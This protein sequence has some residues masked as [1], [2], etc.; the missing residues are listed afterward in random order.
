MPLAHRTVGKFPWNSCRLI[1]ESS[2]AEAVW[3]N[4][5]QVCVKQTLL[6]LAK[7]WKH[8]WKKNRSTSFLW[9]LVTYRTH[10]LPENNHWIHH[11]PHLQIKNS[12]LWRCVWLRQAERGMV[13]RQS[14]CS[15]SPSVWF[16]F[17]MFQVVYC[18]S[19]LE[20]EMVNSPFRKCCA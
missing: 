8:S 10:R 2:S 5:N 9:S 6:C 20:K 12:L 4:L 1:A 19:F 13:E 14:P 7:K 11:D 18:T 16:K 3:N 17:Q 15:P